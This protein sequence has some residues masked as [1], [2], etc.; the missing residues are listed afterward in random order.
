MQF[1]TCHVVTLSDLSLVISLARGKRRQWHRASNQHRLPYM[2]TVTS[3]EQQQHIVKCLHMSTLEEDNTS[4]ECCERVVSVRAG[5]RAVSTGRTLGYPSLDLAQ[6]HTFKAARVCK[7]SPGQATPAASKR[8]VLAPRVRLH[9]QKTTEY[10]K[11]TN[12]S[13]GGVLMPGV[14]V[15]RRGEKPAYH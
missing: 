6:T 2:L 5:H 3:N 11:D 15:R 7:L 13:G 4:M 1:Q 12:L 9:C 10:H 8:C 14:A